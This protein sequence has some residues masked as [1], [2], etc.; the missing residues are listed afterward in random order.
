MAQPGFNR[1]TIFFLIIAFILII[2]GYFF[3]KTFLNS[4]EKAED[5]AME[6][7]ISGKL[8]V[9]VE[10]EEF[11]ECLKLTDMLKG[12]FSHFLE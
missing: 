10:S 1:K 3:I 5:N 4:S 2:A 8:S 9:M 12:E 7:V 6:K 11:C